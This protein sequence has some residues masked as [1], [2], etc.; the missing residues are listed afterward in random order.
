MQV[1]IYTTILS[2]LLT[3]LI[4]LLAGN[5]LSIDR[6]KRQEFNSLAG[7]IRTAL[8]RERENPTTYGGHTDKV[9]F[10][11]FREWL[12]FWKRKRFDLALQNYRDSKGEHNQ[13]RDSMGGVSFK[14]PALVVNSVN[15]LLKFIKPR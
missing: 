7:P 2:S 5:R 1:S 12:P 14:N 9:T 3:G 15:G 11:L 4:G 10:M 13:K 6:D 8:M